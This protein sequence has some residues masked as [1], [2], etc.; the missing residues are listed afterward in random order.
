M[1]RCTEVSACSTVCGA[2]APRRAGAAGPAERPW[3]WST[4]LKTSSTGGRWCGGGGGACGACPCLAPLRCC[5]CTRRSAVW[6]ASLT[7][8]VG[9]VAESC[10]CRPW[11]EAFASG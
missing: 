6:L 7:A 9:S 11:G 2:A 4:L 1:R 3:S 10:R 8:S 5:S